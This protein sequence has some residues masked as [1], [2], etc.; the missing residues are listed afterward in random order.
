MIIDITSAR[1]LITVSG[2]KSPSAQKFLQA[3]PRRP[4]SGSWAGGQPHT[5]WY[6]EG[7]SDDMLQIPGTENVRLMDSEAI[8]SFESLTEQ[9]YSEFKIKLVGFGHGTLYPT[10]YLNLGHF[11][12]DAEPCN[13]VRTLNRPECETVPEL[14]LGCPW[15]PRIDIWCAGATVI[16]STYVC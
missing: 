1:V 11:Y 9:D 15:D 13:V 3:H 10:I 14:L 4:S 5:I 7:S 2:P 12:R 6:A 8:L 16:P